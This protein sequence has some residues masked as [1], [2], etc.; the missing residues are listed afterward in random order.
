MN[1]VTG[2][3]PT[4]VRFENNVSVLS[5]LS[6]NCAMAWVADRQVRAVLYA[7]LAVS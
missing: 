3:H 4:S 2:S 5:E 7:T 6:I 1:W